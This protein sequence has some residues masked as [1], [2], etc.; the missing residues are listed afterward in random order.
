MSRLIDTRTLGG[1]ANSMMASLYPPRTWAATIPRTDCK[2][3]GKKASRNWR[4]TVPNTVKTMLV[5]PP[6]TNLKMTVR[7]DCAILHVTP[8]PRSVYKSSHPACQCLRGF[9]HWT[10]VVTLPLPVAGI[11]NKANLPF[12]QPGLFIGFW[13]ASKRTLPL[14][15][16][17]ASAAPGLVTR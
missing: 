8:S 4:L 15:V 11:W 5:R 2:E 9:G 7:A 6:M 13:A 10:D 16:T 1:E 14:L 3:M 12:H 17:P